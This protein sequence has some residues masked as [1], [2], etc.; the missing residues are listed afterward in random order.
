MAVEIE[1][2]G[3]RRNLLLD[4]AAVALDLLKAVRGY[5]PAIVLAWR[6]AGGRASI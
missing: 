1:S 6:R 5:T 4:D 3:G 2:R